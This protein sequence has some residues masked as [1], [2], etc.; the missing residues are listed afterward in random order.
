MRLGLFSLLTLGIGLLAIG[1]SPSGD[2]GDDRSLRS[3]PQE[4]GTTERLIGLHPVSERVVWASGTGGTYLYTTD[5]GK[6]WRAD[7]VPGADSL[8]F[9]D[10]YA[11]SADTAYL[12]S[13]GRGEQSR[14]YKTTDGGE[15]WTQ[16]FTNSDPEAFFDCIDFWDSDHGLAFSDAV[17][18]TFVLIETTDGGTTWRRIPPEVLPP[19]SKGEASFA[20]SGTCLITQGDSTAYFGTGA[21]DTARLIKTTDRGRTWTAH[22]TPIEAGAPVA[23]I[24]SI[25]FRDS[26]HGAALGG[27]MTTGDPPDSTIVSVALTRDG[28]KTWSPASSVPLAGV[29]GGSYV[30]GA[31]PSTLVVVGPQGLWFTTD[32]GKT[33]QQVENRSYWSVAFAGHDAGWA[34]GPNGRIVHLALE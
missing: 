2:T 1:C 18:G 15:T 33:W 19:A 32:E 28:G 13:I 11:T 26:I 22:A 9:R 29:F 5:G 20:A 34:V 17:Q 27:V 8:Q 31:S 4:S 12:L 25:T 16:S 7:Q 14:I 3:T 24:A 10:V 30:P 6:T 21:V 23:G